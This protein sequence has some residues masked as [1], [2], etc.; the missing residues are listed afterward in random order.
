MNSIKYKPGDSVYYKDLEGNEHLATIKHTQ[1]WH[2]E[3][4]I[5]LDV[6]GEQ[7]NFISEDSI[8]PSWKRREEK[9]NKILGII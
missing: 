9:I 8:R 3:Y 1:S 6:G 4:I 5:T 2:K 7:L